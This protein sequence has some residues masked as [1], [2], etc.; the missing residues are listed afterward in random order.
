[1]GKKNKS[2]FCFSL[3]NPFAFTISLRGFVVA[4]ESRKFEAIV[5]VGEFCFVLLVH[6]ALNYLL[7]VGYTYNLIYV[8]ARLES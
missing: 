7:I 5:R 2:D 4:S 1:M 8:N 6:G 3:F